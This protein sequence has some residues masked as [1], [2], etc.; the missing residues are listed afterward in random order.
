MQILGL[1][2]QYQRHKFTF[3]MLLDAR[4]HKSIHKFGTLIKSYLVL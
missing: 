3:D 1:F 2:D 4:V